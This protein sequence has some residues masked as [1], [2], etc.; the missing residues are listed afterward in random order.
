MINIEE[1]LKPVSNEKPCGEDY[2][3]NPAFQNLETL[4]KGKPE[5]QFSPAEEPQWKEVR[6]AS[7]EVLGKS[8]HLGAAVYLTTALLKTDGLGGL[9][10]GLALMHGLVENYWAGVYPPLD[11]E[12][13][14]DPTER[15]NI[16]GNLSS[17]K[18]IV[19]VKELVLCRTQGLGGITLQQLIAA[20]ERASQSEGAE[21]PAAT[22][23]DWNQI[24]AAMTEAGIEAAKE[25]LGMADGAVV[26]AKGIEGFLDKTLG[27]GNGVN[28]EL[29]NKAL[30]E[31]KNAFAPYASGGEAPAS[32]APADG[33]ADAGGG[34][35][36][37]AEGA[38]AVGG[39]GQAPNPSNKLSGKVQSRAEVIKCLGLIYDYYEKHEPSSP[40]PLVLK[41]A[42][43]LVEKNFMDIVKDLTPDSLKQ[44]KVI[45]GHK[46]E[47]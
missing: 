30:A 31:I 3:Y 39:G 24:Q 26:H 9:R 16:L 1:L 27:A 7:L 12:D 6:D 46:D 25:K 42:E 4:A 37:A 41:R 2:S 45:T 43:R 32:A 17:P 33:A 22:G 20:K 34:N 35:A 5:T 38:S 29:L 18:F 36:A 21:K 13:N 44:L 19:Q 8:K 11:A 23:P 10:D 28:F 40:V 47:E 14:N 15:L